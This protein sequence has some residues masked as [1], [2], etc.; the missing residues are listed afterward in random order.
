MFDSLNVSEIIPSV[1]HFIPII[2]GI[3]LHALSCA[4]SNVRQTSEPR[5]KQ[6]PLADCMSCCIPQKIDTMGMIH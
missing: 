4:R 1:K 2:L 5:A 3:A 6:T